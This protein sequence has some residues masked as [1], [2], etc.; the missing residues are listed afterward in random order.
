MNKCPKLGSKQPKA[1][2]SDPFPPMPYTPSL[3]I[4]HLLKSI[5]HEKVLR[6]ILPGVTQ[7]LLFLVG[8]VTCTVGEMGSMVTTRG[9]ALGPGQRAHVQDHIRLQVFVGVNHSV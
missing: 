2:N 9:D 4:K 8:V 1:I 3:P 7:N 5:G 6:N